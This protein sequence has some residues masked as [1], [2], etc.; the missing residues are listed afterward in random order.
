MDIAADAGRPI[1]A[2]ADGV[3]VE[4]GQDAGYGR[5]VQVKHAE[6]LT[7]LYAHMGR[8]LPNIAAGVAVKAGTPLGLVGS[9]GSSTGAHLHFEIRDR[10]DR[11]LNPPCSWTASS[12]GPTSCRCRPRSA[13]PGEPGS[14]M[15]HASRPTSAP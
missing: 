5:Y 12:P 14:P 8:T 3:V 9:S 10:R 6:G 11:P 1:L 15:C 7:T 13:C 4:V 2:S